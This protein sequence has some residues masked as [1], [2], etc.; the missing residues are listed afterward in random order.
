MRIVETSRAE[1]SRSRNVS[2]LKLDVECML[3]VGICYRGEF[4]TSGNV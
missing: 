3:F 1:T 4:I 2:E